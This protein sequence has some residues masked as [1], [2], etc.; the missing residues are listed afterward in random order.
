M[1]QVGH[2]LGVSLATFRKLT[3]AKCQSKVLIALLI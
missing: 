2:S 3:S 1:Q